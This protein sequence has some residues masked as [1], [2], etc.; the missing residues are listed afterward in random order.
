M[1]ITYRMV[2]FDKRTDELRRVYNL[3]NATLAHAK[4]IARVPKTD[5]D[6]IGDYELNL[7]RARTIL[8]EL[9]KNVKAERYRWFLQSVADWE[10][11]RQ[12]REQAHAKAEGSD[13]PRQKRR[14]ARRADV[15][16]V[17]LP[18]RKQWRKTLRPRR[19][20]RQLR[21]A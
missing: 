7:V 20:H 16:I 9:G 8:S 4:R 2:G 6:L 3:D 10:T 21:R 19:Y 13:V 18:L 14:I 17:S 15:E 1:S 11:I 5:P 12:L